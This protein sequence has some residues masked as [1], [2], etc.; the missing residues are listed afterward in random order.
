MALLDGD[1]ADVIGE[2]IGALGRT[3]VRAFS[4]NDVKTLEKVTDVFPPN[5]VLKMKVEQA[6][7]RE[8]TLKAMQ[9]QDEKR[10]G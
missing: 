6:L 10:N 4:E 8:V 9:E 2:L 7:Q 5:S 3:I 1:T